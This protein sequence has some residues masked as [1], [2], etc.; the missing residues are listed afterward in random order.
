VAERRDGGD[1]S[2]HRETYEA[3]YANIVIP[4]RDVIAKYFEIQA[5]E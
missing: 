2:L 5:G 4:T 3:A 1:T